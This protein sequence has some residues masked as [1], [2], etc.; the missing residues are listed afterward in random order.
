MKILVTGAV[1]FIGSHLVDRLLAR[2]D[3]VVALDCL[4][5]YYD[6]VVKR[7]NLRAAAGHD[8]F[9]LVEGD[10]RDPEIWTTL[11]D[12]DGI[13][14]LAARPGVRLSIEMPVFC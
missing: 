10:I 3:E 13:V 7:R 8:A 1:G 6:P 4:D 2:G 5:D 12:V 11:P 14:H 9:R